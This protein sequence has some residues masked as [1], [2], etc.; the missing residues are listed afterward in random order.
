[1]KIIL[2]FIVAYLLGSIPSGVWVGKIFFKKDIREHGSGNMGTTNTFRVLGKTAGTVV[3]FMDILKG[4]LATALPVIFHVTSVNPLW[5]G[6]CAI[7]GHT[8]PIFAKFKGG[9]AVATSAGMLLGF[10]PLFFL[11]SSAIFVI[12]LYCTSMVSLTSMISAVLITLS[13]IFLPYIAPA[14]LPEPNLLLTLIACGVS[15]FIFYRHKDNIKRIKNKT[16]SRIPFGLN[17]SKKK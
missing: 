11:Y 12:S 7:L 2:L 17:S 5:F 8:F 3:L 4:T 10:N 15:A 13:T 1:M 16:E 6:V 14:I 9:K